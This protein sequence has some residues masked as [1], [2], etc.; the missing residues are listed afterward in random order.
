MGDPKKGYSLI[1]CA[2]TEGPEP[3]AIQFPQGIAPSPGTWGSDG[4][5]EC[6]G[7]I[8]WGSVIL[9]PG[10]CDPAGRFTVFPGPSQ[11]R[12]PTSRHPRAPAG[13]VDVLLTWKGIG[14]KI[15][16]SVRGLSSV[17]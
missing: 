10:F 12:G 3:S 5:L 2:G 7:A 14:A 15:S 8:S 17:L 13:H 4:V 9:W 6:G 1:F 16:S 11:C